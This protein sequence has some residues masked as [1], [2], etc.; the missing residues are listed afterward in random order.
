MQFF[1][2]PKHKRQ[3]SLVAVFLIITLED[4]GAEWE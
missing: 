3:V 1:K 4:V 2:N